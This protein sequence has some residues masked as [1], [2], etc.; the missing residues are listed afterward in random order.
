MPDQDERE[1]YECEACGKS[2]DSEES[3]ERHVRRVG[4]VE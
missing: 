2:F 1:S 4:I 3:L